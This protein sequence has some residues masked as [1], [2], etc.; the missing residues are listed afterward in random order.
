VAH[1]PPI[2]VVPLGLIDYASA[3]AL[4]RSLVEARVAGAIPDVLLL[5]E[6]PP[7]ITHSYTGRGAEHLLGDPVVLASRGVTIETTDRGGDIT[8]HGPGQL[9]GYP[10]VQLDEGRGERDLHRYLRQLEDVLIATA[11]S[12]SVSSVRVPGRTGTWLPCGSKK[13]AAIGVKASR[14]VTMHGFALNVSVDLSFFDL[15]VPCGLGDAGVGNLSEHVPGLQPSLRT[16]AAR[17]GEK[18]CALFGREASPAGEALS[19]L[20]RNHEAVPWP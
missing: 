14:W 3:F 8:F 11:E 9:V 7:T 1:R 17:A 19:I 4:Q 6:H 2:A 5:L 10:I 15:I 18:F 13:L 20:L 12:F 16:V